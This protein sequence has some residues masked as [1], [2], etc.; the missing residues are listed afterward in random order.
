MVMLEKIGM[1]TDKEE[2]ARQALQHWQ[3]VQGIDTENVEVSPQMQAMMNNA[4]MYADKDEEIP[5][6]FMG[7]GRS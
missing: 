7:S 5:G 1:E 4:W 2:E 3:K 6:N